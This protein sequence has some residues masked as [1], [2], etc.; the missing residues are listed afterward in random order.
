MKFFK[1][2]EKKQEKKGTL[3]ALR[4]L[5]G[6]Y[7]DCVRLLRK[8]FDKHDI[9][10]TDTTVKVD[11]ADTEAVR[12]TFESTDDEFLEIRFALMK[13]GIGEIKETKEEEDEK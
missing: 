5:E 4:V 7:E 1:K 13:K 2:E 3:Y 12:L 11:G 10:M 9:R 6:G 8:D